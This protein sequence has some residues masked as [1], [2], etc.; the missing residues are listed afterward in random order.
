[1]LVNTP[2]PITSL[3]WKKAEPI[4]VKHESMSCRKKLIEDVMF[5]LRLALDL[6]MH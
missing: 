5:L 1:M 2:Q 6:K 4:T 3:L